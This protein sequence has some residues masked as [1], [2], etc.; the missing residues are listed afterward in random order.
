[1]PSSQQC[2]GVVFGGL[3]GEHLIS[4]KSATTVINA[5]RSSVNRQKFLT[6]PFY[7]DREGR[8]HSPEVGEKVLKSQT[9]PSENDLKS[10]NKI[11]GFQGFPKDSE[12]I[13]IWFP[14]LHGPNGEDGSIQG[15][16][17]MNRKP[18]VGSGVLGSALGMDKLAMKAAFTAAGLDQVPY[19]SLIRDEIK[20]ADNLQKIIKEIER[21]LIY[22]IFIKPANLGSSVGITKASNQQELILGLNEA[23]KY[24]KRIVAEEGV[25]AMELEC[26][27]L[28]ENNE[29]KASEVGQVEFESE[30]FNYQTKYTQ[31]NSRSLIPA[32]IP[33][34]IKEKVQKL[35]I[36]ACQAISIN[37]MSRVD[38]FYQKSKNKLWINEINTLPGFTSESMFP[39][40]WEASG[41]PLEKLVEK[42][43]EATSNEPNGIY[44][45]Q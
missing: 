40:L 30:W 17:Q 8:W 14:M 23:S 39:L 19:K 22:P 10:F 1:M 41:I 15:L 2:V 11:Y 18:F 37:G 12:I 3:S 25:D 26:A 43:L 9:F 6:I 20:D 4:I 32:P 21:E 35:S 29:L 44:S 24:D 45:H 34:T 5:L 33:N 16:F 13:D 28:E 36:E 7:I 42:L 27:V 38:F 31:G